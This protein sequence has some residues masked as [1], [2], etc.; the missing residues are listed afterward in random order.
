MANNEK[1]ITVVFPNGS[2]TDEDAI[3]D[4]YT[5]THNNHSSPFDPHHHDHDFPDFFA[6]PSEMVWADAIHQHYLKVICALG[7]PGNLAA[8]VTIAGMKPRSVATFLVALLAASDSVALVM[9]LVINQLFFLLHQVNDS[10]C[11]SSHLVNVCSTYANWVLVLIAAERLVAVVWPMLRNRFL[12][13]ARVY[14]L[15]G[16]LALPILAV[17]APLVMAGEA[18]GRYR[19]GLRGEGVVSYANGAWVVLNNLLYALLPIV[20]LMAITAALS[21]ALAK[22]RRSRQQLLGSVGSKRSCQAGRE[23]RRSERAITTMMLAASFLFMLMVLPQC[24]YFIL[25]RYTQVL[26]HLQYT[27]KDHLI[28]QTTTLLADSTHALNFY[29]YFVSVR[30]FRQRVLSLLCC[31]ARWGPCGWRPPLSNHSSASRSWSREYS[32]NNAS[33]SHHHHAHHAKKSSPRGDEGPELTTM[34]TT[35]A[36]TTTYAEPASVE[37]EC[38]GASR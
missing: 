24:M 29:L 21:L 17:H 30:R 31:R 22:A 3:L 14:C 13:K 28:R 18:K 27:P 8:I 20:L 23:M 36:F 6:K 4:A 26:T 5:T 38:L 9:K 25:F 15:C 10:Y 1:L 19:C 12:G 11:R 37:M 35:T 34:T 2:Y 7:L 32:N 33:H 16:I